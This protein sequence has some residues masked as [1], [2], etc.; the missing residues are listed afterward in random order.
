[1]RSPGATAA[2][3][4]LPGWVPVPAFLSLCLPSRHTEPEVAVGPGSWL[5]LLGRGGGCQGP[6]VPPP[7]FLSVSSTLYRPLWLTLSS[8]RCVCFCQA[9]PPKEP[10]VLQKHRRG[11]HRL[12]LPLSLPPPCHL[13][14]EDPGPASACSSSSRLLGLDLPPPGLTE[15]AALQASSR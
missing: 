10:T 2:V 1:M 12:P 4:E 15:R 5:A 6:S 13:R 9:E 3:L 8:P 11:E 7:R 14:S